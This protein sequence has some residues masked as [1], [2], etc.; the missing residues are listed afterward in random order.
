[1]SNINDEQQ[2]L[3]AEG[4]LD[5]LGEDKTYNINDLP[6]VKRLL[7]E[8]A[9]QF[10]L[11]VKA[12]IDRPDKRG[13]VLN[14]TGALSDGVVNTPIVDNNGDISFSVGYNSKSPAAKYFDFVNEGVRGIVDSTLAPNSP[15]SFKAAKGIRPGPSMRAAL[16]QWLKNNRQKITAAK[17]VNFEKAKGLKN[18]AGAAASQSKRQTLTEAEQTKGIVYA[19]GANIRKKGIYR[20]LFFNRA[21]DSTFNQAFFDAVASVV[22]AD[23]SVGLRRINSLSND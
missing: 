19:I 14:S 8:A 11:E 4:F 10:I 5:Q 22:G 9:A 13:R 20:S 7:I 3:L 21:L 17:P 15:Y 18:K 2:R 16:E 1:M 6:L 23:I 12:N